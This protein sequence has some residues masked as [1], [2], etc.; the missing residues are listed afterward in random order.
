MKK[1]KVAIAEDE[2]L[3]RENI[4]LM[5]KSMGADV[6]G[7]SSSGDGIIKK[8]ILTRPDVILMDIRLKGSK[9]GVQAAHEINSVIKIPVVFMSAYVK[10]ES[11][12]DLNF[13]LNSQYINKPI[14]HKELQQ[15][16]RQI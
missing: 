14:N 2:V 8:S 7:E 4:K 1:I 10:P 15:A 5:L 16:L 13:P 6:V 3:I 9:N 11:G 12:K